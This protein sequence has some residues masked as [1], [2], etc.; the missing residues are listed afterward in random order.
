MLLKIVDSQSVSRHPS[1]L[2]AAMESSGDHS[3]LA[4]EVTERMIAYLKKNP[5][6][7]LQVFDHIRSFC[8]IKGTI[9]Q[10]D[11]NVYLETSD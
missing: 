9:K 4:K 6:K 10:K 5:G 8:N 2:E 1:I 3:D 11:G 7:M